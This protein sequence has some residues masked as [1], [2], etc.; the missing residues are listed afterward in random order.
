MKF[1]ENNHSILIFIN[2]KGT[3]SGH[4]DYVHCVCMRTGTTQFLS[5]AEDGTVR[6]WGQFLDS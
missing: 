2:G 5:G 4:S 3:F 6:I 1:G